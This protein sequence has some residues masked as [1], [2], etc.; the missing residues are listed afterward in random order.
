[1]IAGHTKSEI[2]L[3][4]R[5]FRHFRITLRVRGTLGA[6]ICPNTDQDFGV[7]LGLRGQ[8]AVGTAADRLKCL[9]CADH[10]GAAVL[11]AI[12]TQ[13]LFGRGNAES[14]PNVPAC[15]FLDFEQDPPALLVDPSA[16]RITSDRL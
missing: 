7:L 5:T 16:R 15:L 9:G 1:M 13:C 4:T 11:V 8:A 12:E 10:H 6:T 14:L 3:K 2:K